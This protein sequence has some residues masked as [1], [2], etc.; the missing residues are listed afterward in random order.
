MSVPI[1]TRKKLIE[2]A[3]PLESVN[4]ASVR[5]N[6]IYRGN[7]SSMHKWW[8]Q[9]PLAAARAVIFAQMVDDPS[10]YTDDL[11]LVH[12]KLQDAKAELKRREL[13]WN[14]R[15]TDADG[16]EPPSLEECA[17]D[18]ERERLFRII[19]DLVKWENTNNDYVLDKAHAEILRSWQRACVDNADHPNADEL[20]D[21][22]NPPK[23]H[24]PFAGGSTLP[25]EAQRL[26]LDAYGSD[27]N[28]VAVLI[29]KAL[30]ELP[31][32]FADMPPVN[33]AADRNRSWAGSEGLSD[34]VRYYGSWICSELNKKLSDL[35]PDV[36]I[37][38]EVAKGRPDLKPFIGRELPVI[39]W[40][41]AR[42]VKSP[43]PAFRDV[44]VPLVSTFMVSTK[45][46]SEVWLKPVLSG[47]S[48][49][50]EACLGK[51][52]DTEAAKSGT[53]AGKR[54]NFR[55]LM[56]GTPIDPEYIKSEG[57][58]GRIGA[59]MLTAV[60]DADGKRLYVSPTYEQETVALQVPR[61]PLE[62]SDICGSSQYVGTRAY[63][64]DSF[65][66]LF[67]A[68]QL[69]ALVCMEETLKGIS[70]RIA[71]D[72]D[73]G[74]FDRAKLVAYSD[75]IITYLAFAIDKY[76]TYGNSLVPWYPKENRP[77]MLFSQQV[78]PIVWDYAE[79]NPLSTI[80]GSLSKSID[81]VANSFS[82]LPHVKQPA[83]VFQANAVDVDSPKHCVV[84][85]DPP[86][87][88][89]VPYA[90]LSDF[91]Y[92]ILRRT[93]GRR[94]PDLFRT[95]ATPK[96]EEL[97]AA[98][99]RHG[100][101]AQAEHFFLEGM[102]AAMTRLADRSHGSYPLTIYYA[103]KQSESKG[104]GVSSTGWETF[105]DA[106]VQSGLSINGTWPVRTERTGRV[107]DSGSNALA[108]S[109]VLV[110]RPRDSSA[111]AISRRD[112]L[113][114]L[115]LELP[116]ALKH[117]QRGNIAPVDLAQAA[118]G[119]GMATFT[120]HSQ[121]LDAAGKPMSVR[122][123][124]AR[125]NEVLDEVLAAQEGDFDP[126]TRWA[127]TWFDQFGFEEGEFGTADTLSKAKGTAVAEMADPR[128]GAIITAKA[129]KVK[130]NRPGELPA[131]W[132]PTTDPRLTVWEMV[133]HLI[134]Q[135]EDQGESAAAD[136]MAALGAKAE[137]AREL[138]YRLY[139]I[140]ERK[141]RS[142]E[143]QTYNALVQS[144][145]EMTRLARDLVASGA[146]GPAQA[147]LAI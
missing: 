82:G 104:D 93:V 111:A 61:P 34:D 73:T 68:R 108:S 135:M 77:S 115:K 76:A 28:P 144:W 142:A 141:K 92:S 103:F 48:Y 29:N 133:H 107:R 112:F 50:F 11:L 10:E 5:E 85:T 119:P 47:H 128:N 138:A 21:P 63:G 110:C 106:V 8:A 127:V 126:D 140:C 125:I 123:A 20:F 88:D 44:D 32:K 51:P 143:G 38:A 46:G 56:S 24:D 33:P 12:E 83:K 53:K 116:A 65:D 91:F 26:R 134:R 129:G 43:N 16:L 97:V 35:Y 114:S 146:T 6:Y 137:A 94:Y 90:D 42:T 23:F 132:D 136:L 71:A 69:K 19:E 70:D 39:A 3:L 84:S 30:I 86:Y 57:Q 64:M 121:V 58:A 101:K 124:L 66:K 80:G 102:T 27:L 36:R 117:L 74:K 4:I 131:E 15:E 41:W 17:A 145:P 25:L 109:I 59:R 118:I 1:K 13:E 95:M 9:R 22:K 78:F 105:L 98:T 120:R 31:P 89:N 37:T 100:G 40:L 87:Y 14:N 122:E 139:A 62:T 45:P 54:A 72:V 96:Q 60:V 99:H 79:V 113:N 2:V 75:A 55:C 81:V 67:S 7:P 147:E 52:T 18:I 130:L 49:H